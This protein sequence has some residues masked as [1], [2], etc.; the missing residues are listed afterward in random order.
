MP[1]LK[2]SDGRKIRVPD[3]YTPDQIDEVVED[4]MGAKSTPQSAPESSVGQ[5]VAK[6]A[7]GFGAGLTKQVPGSYTAGGLLRTA[8]DPYFDLSEGLKTGE[9]NQTPA[10]ESFKE[11]YEGTKRGVEKLAS[12]APIASAAGQVVAAIPE[13]TMGMGALGKGGKL[14]QLAKGALTN[15]AIGQ[16][17]R[18][19]EVDLRESGIDALTGAGGEALGIGLN[20]VSES[21]PGIRAKLYNSAF[22]VTPKE[23]QAGKNLGQDIVDMGGVVGTKKGLYKKAIEGLGAQDSALQDILSKTKSPINRDIVQ[24]ELQQ[25]VNRF[26][27]QPL[28]DADAQVAQNILDEW[29]GKYANKQYADQAN[30]LKRE[31]YQ[32]LG[33]RPYMAENLPAKKDALKSMA[34]G[35]M[36]SVEDAAPEVKPVNKKLGTY[37][38]LKKKLEG[39][40]AKGTSGR[41]SLMD[42]VK[43]TG[44]GAAGYAVG[45]T[46]GI[47][48]AMAARSAANSTL[49]KTATAEALK[50]LDALIK[51]GGARYL[52]PLSMGRQ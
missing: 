14:A 12:K 34:K 35:L 24:N 1:V 29:V 43:N 30:Q 9:F 51:S 6:Q 33:D 39:Q 45:G 19:R 31:I 16:G 27:G 48:A 52:G 50:Y 21:I 18:G 37:V 44:L 13:Y 4:A 25:L 15:A 5:E 41:E 20:K 32:M 26:K 46:T 8:I 47:P 40:L 36:K 10:L 28:G 2:L 11:G 23:I 49:G 17:A 7:K 22:G 3:D 38:G 42:A